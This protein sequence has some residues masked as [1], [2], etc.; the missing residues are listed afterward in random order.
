MKILGDKMKLRLL[1]E[2]R[3]QLGWDQTTV[4]KKAKV[5]ISTLSLY[6]RSKVTPS[7]DKLNRI[8]DVLGIKLADVLN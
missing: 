3:I 5:S 2:K 4:C 6:E 8:C 1:K 7:A